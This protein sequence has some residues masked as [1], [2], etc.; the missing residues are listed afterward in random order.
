MASSPRALVLC[1]LCSRERKQFRQTDLTR[2]DVYHISNSIAM[3]GRGITT[4]AFSC[5]AAIAMSEC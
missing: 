2:H 1:A 3:V 4:L 5:E